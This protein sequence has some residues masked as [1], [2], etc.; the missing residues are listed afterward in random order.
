MPWIYWLNDYLTPVFGNRL[1]IAARHG[2]IRKFAAQQVDSR[3]EKDHGQYHDLLS[4]LFEVNKEKPNE[5]NENAVLSMATSNVFA[6]SDTTAISL[7][8]IIYYLL[9]NPQCK[10]KFI[11]EIDER[12]KGGKLS[13]PVKL[14]EANEMPYLQACMYEALRL[15]PAVGMSL[16]RV[17]PAD[18]IEIDGKFLPAGT[19]VGVNPWVVHRDQEVF[20]EDVETFRPERWLERDRSDMDRFFFAF[21]S[22]ARVCLGRNISWMEMSK[23][24]PTL[25]SKFDL[26]LANPEASWKETCW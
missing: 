25:F 20:G 13:D 6:G 1:G 19:I 8:S 3:K 22:G 15:H 21:G 11:S 9:K 17:V 12:K 18:G 5:M 14:E 4:R 16:P 24:V 7:R 26:Q 2:S 10:K 23:L